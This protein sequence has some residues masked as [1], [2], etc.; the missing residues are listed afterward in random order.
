MQPLK[1]LITTFLAVATVTGHPSPEPETIVEFQPLSTK[2]V[3]YSAPRHDIH[4][5]GS[6]CSIPHTPRRHH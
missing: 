5:G 1:I 4:C 3:F 2:D 6:K